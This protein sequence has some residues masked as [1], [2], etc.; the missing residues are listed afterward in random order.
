[1]DLTDRRAHALQQYTQHTHTFSVS[2]YRQQPN[3]EVISSE[4]FRGR[5]SPRV[6]AAICVYSSVI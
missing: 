2:G 1:M 3:M 5:L 4:I 6:F